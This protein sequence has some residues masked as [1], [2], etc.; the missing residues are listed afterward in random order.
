MSGVSIDVVGVRDPSL[1]RILRLAR[2]HRRA[3]ASGIS[4]Q[5]IFLLLGSAR[6]NALRFVLQA[7]PADEPIACEIEAL[8]LDHRSLGVRVLPVGMSPP[9]L[10]EHEEQRIMIEVEAERPVDRL[11]VV[12]SDEQA[13]GGAV[14]VGVQTAAVRR[15]ALQA[16]AIHLPWRG[17]S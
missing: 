15:L 9:S 17:C 5:L 14:A 2:R 3:Q 11:S 4:K 10:D 8:A 16:E 7:E 12:V 1:R 13:N 6:R